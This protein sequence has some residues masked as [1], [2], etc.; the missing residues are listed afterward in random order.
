MNFTAV[1]LSLFFVLSIDKKLRVI[2]ASIFCI[3]VEL[4]SSHYSVRTASFFIAFVQPEWSPS[5]MNMTRS[6]Q[7]T[8]NILSSLACVNKAWYNVALDICLHLTNNCSR[9]ISG[10]GPL[11]PKNSIIL[12][13]DSIVYVYLVYSIKQTPNNY[14]R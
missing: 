6:D 12:N 4:I 8:Y 3:W 1:F 10:R 5:K 7:C 14:I 13:N 9:P 2:F 11:Q